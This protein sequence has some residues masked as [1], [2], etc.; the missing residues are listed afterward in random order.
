MTSK[1]KL[2]LVSSGELAI[3]V[4]SMRRKENIP[5][6]EICEA[7]GIDPM[8]IAEKPIHAKILRD[9]AM[10]RGAYEQANRFIELWERLSES[11]LQSS[12]DVSKLAAQAKYL[13]EGV[14]EKA[15]VR[16]IELTQE[17]LDEIAAMNPANEYDIRSAY[18]ELR[19]TLE[20]YPAARRLVVQTQA[21]R[22]Y[23][24]SKK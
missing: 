21:R 19:R 2:T 10:R 15:L 5:A 1:P 16:L 7:N 4:W 24:R 11:F 20:N 22:H 8:S 23:S 17:R 18:A 13:A 6:L 14:Q 3:D 9:E 12:N